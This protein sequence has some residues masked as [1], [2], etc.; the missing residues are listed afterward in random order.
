MVEGESMD[1]GA[2]LCNVCFDSD[3]D[4]IF[5]PCSHGGL[6][7]KC[8]YDIWKKTNECYICRN[9]VEYILRYD[10]KNKKGNKF[11]I[12]EVHQEY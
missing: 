6:C 10:T 5:M 12:I 1:E 9:V 4:S 7:L 8:S 3:A 2:A 11:K